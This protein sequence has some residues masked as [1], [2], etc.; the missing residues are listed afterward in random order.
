M[1]T[2]RTTRPER[3]VRV[4]PRRPR[5]SWAAGRS[6]NPRPARGPA[7]ALEDLAAVAERCSV[8][9][10]RR[11]PH[12]DPRKEPAPVPP[13][14]ERVAADR[15][16]HGTGLLVLGLRNAGRELRVE[17]EGEQRDRLPAPGGPTE[18]GLERLSPLRIPVIAELAALDL[19]L[20][21]V[22]PAGREEARA[23]GD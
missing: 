2:D 1:R 4:A 23:V 7:P 10:D 6:K 22:D 15:D 13:P 18:L 11:L 5:A 8:N 17:T 14:V 3:T 21:P 19:P 16:G 12:G 9:G 20:A